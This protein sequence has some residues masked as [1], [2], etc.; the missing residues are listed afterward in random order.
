M[1]LVLLLGEWKVHGDGMPWSVRVQWLWQALRIMWNAYQQQD[2]RG[3]C[4]QEL[5]GQSHHLLTHKE[6]C[7][8]FIAQDNRPQALG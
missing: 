4:T 7:T 1:S 2:A 6:L 5:R 3:H 8:G